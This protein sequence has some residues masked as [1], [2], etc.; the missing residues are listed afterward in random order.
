MT[1][2]PFAYTNRDYASLLADLRRRMAVAIP[3]W[4]AYDQGFES[5][6]L[7]LMA[8]VGDQENFYIDRMGNEAFLQGAVRRESVLNLADMFG[9]TPGAQTAAACTVQFSKLA[10]LAEDVTI[11]AGTQLFAQIE[12]QPPVYFETKTSVTL[13]AANTTVT[14]TALEGQTITQEAVGNSNG[15]AGQSFVAFHANVIRDSVHVYTKDGPLDIS[16]NPTLVEWTYFPKLIDANFYDRAFTLFTD[17]HNFSYVVFGDGVSG[18]VPGNASPVVVTYR[19]GVGSKGNV[20]IGAV[21][22]FVSGGLLTTKITAVTNTT[23]ATGGNDAESLE[24]MRS[25]IPRS[26]RS[27]ERA[28]T[29]ADYSALTLHVAGVSKANSTATVSTSVT[30]YVAP[31]GGGQPSSDLLAACAAYFNGPPSRAMIG[32]SLTFTGPTYVPINVTISVT[33]NAKYR[34]DTVKLAVT[35][36]IA[37]LYSFDNRLFAELLSKAVL[38]R[39]VIDIDGVSY[40]D[41]TVFSRTGSGTT[42]IQLAVN[43]IATLGTLTINASGGVVLS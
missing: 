38:F 21:R 15:G 37:T 40:A 19:Y 10:T 25:S 31:A 5:I 2:R 11:P 14:V 28:V 17:E 7:E 4:T 18:V 3:E 9:Y 16:G 39:N 12:G 41:I 34:Q 23:A 22:S 42:D 33:V 24:S 6:L 32:T 8:Y 30:T 13:I 26:L 36:A 43:E 35:N 1:A 27:L 29:L 20:G